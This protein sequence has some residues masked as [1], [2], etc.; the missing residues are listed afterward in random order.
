MLAHGISTHSQ[1]AYTCHGLLFTTAI[2]IYQLTSACS[3]FAELLSSHST[4]TARRNNFIFTYF[5]Q[6]CMG[7]WY[8]YRLPG[9]SQAKKNVL[10]YAAPYRPPRFAMRSRKTAAQLEGFLSPGSKVDMWTAEGC[11]Y[12]NECKPGSFLLFLA[13]ECSRT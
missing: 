11:L 3:N 5:V 2:T 4:L 1:R 10:K 9:S 12:T 8:I 6:Q 7:Y 13:T